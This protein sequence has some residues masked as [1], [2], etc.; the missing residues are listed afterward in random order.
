MEMAAVVGQEAGGLGQDLLDE[1]PNARLLGGTRASHVQPENPV[2]LDETGQQQ[3]RLLGLAVNVQPRLRVL[4]GQFHG[5]PGTS[6]Q[7]GNQGENHGAIGIQD[8]PLS[9]LRVV[10]AGS[11]LKPVIIRN[12]TILSSAP[13]GQPSTLRN[14]IGNGPIQ[15]RTVG[16]GLAACKYLW[17]SGL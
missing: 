5:Q 4:L 12:P 3:C 10:G 2:P 14:S 8:I 9:P 11:F 13:L 17:E 1:M 15:G 7:F 6:S 16:P